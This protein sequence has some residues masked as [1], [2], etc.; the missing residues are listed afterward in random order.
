ME[1]TR[2][3]QHN[4]IL[5]SKERASQKLYQS[6]I[7][8][9]LKQ[10]FGLVKKKKKRSSRSF[11]WES[12]VAQISRN[13]PPYSTSSPISV[14][15]RIHFPCVAKASHLL[16][17][18]VHIQHAMSHSF[19]LGLSHMCCFFWFFFLT[20]KPRGLLNRLKAHRRVSLPQPWA[21]LY[22]SH[23]HCYHG[24]EVTCVQIDFDPHPLRQRR[25]STSIMQLSNYG[26]FMGKKKRPRARQVV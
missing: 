13:F 15:K 3:A 2:A 8:F 9:V 5:A 14:L 25:A 11:V 16:C 22:F 6:T 17:M 12:Q 23:L 1:M 18:T 10:F 26:R 4:E 20:R 21:T 24:E 19:A 7:V